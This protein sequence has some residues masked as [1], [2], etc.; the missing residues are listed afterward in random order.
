MSVINQVESKRWLWFE[1]GL[2]LLILFMVLIAAGLMVW[3]NLERLQQIRSSDE[4]I[5]TVNWTI[6]LAATPESAGQAPPATGEGTPA[7]PPVIDLSDNQEAAL[8]F[9]AANQALEK[10]EE[11]NADAQNS[12]GFG[13]ACPQLSGGRRF[14]AGARIGRGGDFQV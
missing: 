3:T 2:Y 7:A 1:R 10:A 11:A 12:V 5:H 13:A 14:S 8:L 9:E 4:D 6:S